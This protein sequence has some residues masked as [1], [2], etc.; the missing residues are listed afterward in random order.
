MRTRPATTPHR[1]ARGVDSGG[2]QTVVGDGDAPTL[3]PRTVLS[4]PGIILNQPQTQAHRGRGDG[5]AAQLSLSYPS[6]WTYPARHE[7]RW[8]LCPD[9]WWGFAR[10]RVYMCWWLV[11]MCG[12]SP[13][14]RVWRAQALV[15]GWTAAGPQGW[16]R[17]GPNEEQSAQ[18]RQN[19]FIFPFLFLVFLLLF[20][21]E[22]QTWIQAFVANFVPNF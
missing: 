19:V 22:F 18:S 12:R 17:H 1:S 21:F 20:S 3:Q 9:C 16:G 5:G 13:V 14:A 10:D 4:S 8:G 6:R 2:E 11:Y 15:G 7:R